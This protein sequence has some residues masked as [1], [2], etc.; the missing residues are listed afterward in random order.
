MAEVK[1]NNE[2]RPSAATPRLV[3]F[4]VFRRFAGLSFKGTAKLLLSDRPLGEG[5]SPIARADASR[6]W[7][8]REVVHGVDRLNRAGLFG[9][10][11]EGALRVLS[12]L[13]ATRGRDASEILSELTDGKAA[14][15]MLE[16]L[17]AAD[18][19]PTIY[20]NML[21]RLTCNRSLTED[22]RAEIAM[23]LFVAAG[24]LQDGRE[25]VRTA[26]GFTYATHGSRWDADTGAES[27]CVRRRPLGFSAETLVLGLIRMEGGVMVGGPYRVSPNCGGVTVGMLALGENDIVDVE[28]D[29]SDRHARIWCDGEGAWWVE[30]LCSVA[31]TIVMRTGEEGEL[32]LE[33]G[34]PERI[35]SGDTLRF[36]TSTTYVVAKGVQGD[37]MSWGGVLCDGLGG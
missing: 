27:S 35:E 2:R 28:S 25:A 13:K 34:C 6:T 33:A 26:L 8:S 20:G 11:D 21:A 18:A 5:P 10:C 3:M 37:R 15:L 9:D 16:A 4:E 36:G 12:R 30:D 22:E 29:V 14:D 1:S 17:E 19:A 31:G 24:C 32:R 23:V 7:M